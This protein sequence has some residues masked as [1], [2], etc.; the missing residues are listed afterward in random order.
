MSLKLLGEI[1]K[2]QKCMSKYET[3]LNSVHFAEYFTY[4]T[5]IKSKIFLNDASPSNNSLNYNDYMTNNRTPA[6]HFLKC[7][8]VVE[9]ESIFSCQT[10]HFKIPNTSDR[11]TPF[12]SIKIGHK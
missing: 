11:F 7:L 9:I 12:M 8:H 10:F 3:S 4:K 2:V 5:F 1:G 6:S